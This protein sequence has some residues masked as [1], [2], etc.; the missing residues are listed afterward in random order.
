MKSTFQPTFLGKW[1]KKIKEERVGTETEIEFLTPEPELTVTISCSDLNQ[2]FSDSGETRYELQEGFGA[3]T[4][5]TIEASE[6]KNG[7]R[8]SDIISNLSLIPCSLAVSESN[9]K[10]ALSR[11][12]EGQAGDRQAGR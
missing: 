8:K 3:R 2:Q 10:R 1:L 7:I 5:T 11:S 9:L 6:G 12:A 4:V